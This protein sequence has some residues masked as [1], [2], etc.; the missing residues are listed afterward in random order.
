MAGR[1]V[2]FLAH[3]ARLI[4]E[5][6]NAGAQYLRADAWKTSTP[7]SAKGSNSCS[8]SPGERAT[9]ASKSIDFHWENRKLIG[10]S[11]PTALRTAATISAANLARA[12]RSPP[13]HEVT[14]IVNCI[15]LLPRLTLRPSEIRIL[16][17]KRPTRLHQ[18][19][20]RYPMGIERVST[21]L[22]W[23]RLPTERHLTRR[24]AAAPDTARPAD[25]S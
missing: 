10:K 2:T 7:A 11:G 17:V 23:P 5:P 20:V 18:G 21:C 3:P 19:R 15:E 1:P 16:S 22:I 6:S 9:C 12:A 24:A 14:L 13:C 25:R 4:L 8:S